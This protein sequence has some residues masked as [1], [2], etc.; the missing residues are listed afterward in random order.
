MRKLASYSLEAVVESPADSERIAT[1]A[2]R[3]VAD[4]ISNKGQPVDG[5]AR[6]RIIHDGRI[7]ELTRCQQ[8]TSKGSFTE[9]IVTEPTP[10]G[11]FRTSLRVAREPGR[12]VFFC[13]LSA[14]SQS[15]MPLW[16][17][18]HCP[19][20][21]RDV[22]AIPANWSYGTSKLYATALNYRGATGGDE[23]IG[24]VWDQQRAVPVVAIS[25]EYGLVLHRGMV[26]AM[27]ADLVGLAVVARLDP[28]ASWRVTSLK[29]KTWSCYGGAIRLYWP[30][31]TSDS[32]PFDHPLWTPR[33]L[34]AGVAD[35]ETAAG[36]I[37]SQLRRRIL[38]QSAFAVREH[39]LLAAIRRAGREDEL[40]ALW[41]RSQ[42]TE[43]YRS[44]A[45]EYFEKLTQMSAEIGAKDEEIKGLRDQVAN[46]QLALRWQNESPDSVEPVEDTPPATVE[47]AVL[48]AIERFESN[49]VFGSNVNDGLNSLAADAGPPDKILSYLEILSELTE[50]RR[51]GSLG[52]M[53]IMWLEE[54]GVSASGES[55]TVRRSTTEMQNRTWDDGSGQR[56]TFE[57]HLKP[58]EGTSPDRCVRI[59]FDYDEQRGKTVVGWVGRHP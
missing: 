29:G 12:V 9:S 37:R 11:S 44:I 49:L 56:K 4:W 35:A 14:G 53:P 32:T 48:T 1:T 30:R 59:Y 8:A 16:V 13:E 20:V 52:T 18:V 27:A 47:E 39:E 22:L 57:M 28:E 42:S 43:D 41:A 55:E 50:A 34:L 6:L 17:D 36:R 38:G 21:I 24:T 7:A 45:E 3:C 54:R 46:L 33:R 2:E 5:G 40:S 19:K 58:N 23:F 51:K 26:E 15:L 10:N 25:E 31:I